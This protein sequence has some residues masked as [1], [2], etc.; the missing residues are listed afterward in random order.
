MAI[1]AY[2][3]LAQR[4]RKE[5]DCN[6]YLIDVDEGDEFLIEVG[7][8]THIPVIPMDIP[9]IPA[10]KILA[11]ARAYIS[12]RYHPSILASLGGT[13][14]V[15]MGS[16]SHKTTSIQELLQY[17]TIKEYNVLPDDDECSKIICDAREKI[18]NRELRKT[19]KN[20]AYELCNE[21]KKIV[22]IIR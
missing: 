16:N 18:N 22:E 13:P 12:G 7:R 14:C 1:E 4:I 5:L 20:R 10:A 3:N 9:L 2:S 11:N 21:A 15:F 8:R 6:V 19:I 17:E